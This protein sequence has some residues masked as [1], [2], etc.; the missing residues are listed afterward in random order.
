MF[1]AAVRHESHR[2][3]LEMFQTPDGR[4]IPGDRVIVSKSGRVFDLKKREDQLAAMAALDLRVVAVKGEISVTSLQRLPIPDTDP[5]KI[6]EWILEVRYKG[7][8]IA[9]ERQPKTL[10]AALNMAQACPSAYQVV[11]R[12]GWGLYDPVDPTRELVSLAQS[13]SLSRAAPVAALDVPAPSRE[14]PA[15]RVEGGV[16]VFRRAPA[17]GAVVVGGVSGARSG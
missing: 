5:T 1:D 2:L 13:V 7:V 16:R 3:A 11:K 12:T 15:V 6:R 9:A 8:W 17:G 14:V 4:M 10:L